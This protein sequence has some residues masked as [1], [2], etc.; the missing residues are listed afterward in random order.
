LFSRFFLIDLF[1]NANSFTVN[2]QN[3]VYEKQYFLVTYFQNY[4]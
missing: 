4:S 3:L 2:K 1:S